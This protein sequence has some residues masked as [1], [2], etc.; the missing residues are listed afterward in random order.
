VYDLN[1]P[2]QQT[3]HFCHACWD[4]LQLGF[5]THHPRERLPGVA[6]SSSRLL[7]STQVEGYVRLGLQLSKQETFR[8]GETGDRSDRPREHDLYSAVL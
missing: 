8:V 1:A 5:H 6:A 2:P 4:V 3:W 7:S